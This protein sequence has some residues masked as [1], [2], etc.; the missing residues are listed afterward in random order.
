MFFKVS[1][2]I[3]E[4]LARAAAAR[5]CARTAADP[6]R[7]ADLLDMELRWLR[8]VESY[9]FVE[10][11]DRFLADARAQR[12]PAEEAAQSAGA[13]GNRAS[14]AELLEVLVHAA[15]EQTDGKARAAFYL[16][17]GEGSALHH[18]T[19]M[20]RAYARHV[21][22]FAISPQSLACGLAAATRHAVITPDVIAE[23]C[24]E[25]WLWLAKE[26][27]YRACWSFPV[28]TPGGRIVGTFA[29]YYRE[30]TEATPRHLDFASVLT[31]TAATIISKV[32]LR[33]SASSVAL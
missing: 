27:D 24:W 7:K 3:N 13:A 6:D 29:M 8:L 10:Q 21:D 19:G 22:G 26:F 5:E 31:R 4:C 1:A 2:K 30:P 16:A 14:L 11:A 18:I 25:Q 23:P 15:I 9:K 28:E 17:D 12:Q 33:R 32:D 20:P